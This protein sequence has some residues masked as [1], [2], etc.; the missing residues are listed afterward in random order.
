MINI[1]NL[2]LEKLPEMDD[3]VIEFS[4]GRLRDFFNYGKIRSKEDALEII[5]S[6]GLLDTCED[7]GKYLSNLTE[8][9]HAYTK[10][11][12]DSL[13]FCHFV[14][15]KVFDKKRTRMGYRLKSVD[16]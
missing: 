9:I 4:G 10:G 2:D 13:V 5:T 7:A 16:V 12:G 14:V 15:E 3:F 8:Q 1:V 11:S 6:N